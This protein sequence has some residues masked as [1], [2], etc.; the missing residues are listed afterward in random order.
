MSR[1]RQTAKH[2]GQTG[3][4]IIEV[5]IAVAVV[6]SV[7]GITYSIM[8]RNILIMR[9]NQERTEASKIA[10]AQVEMLKSAWNRTHP[11]VF[12][13]QVNGSFCVTRDGDINSSFT[14]A[15][16]TANL[17]DDNL[18]QYPEACRH[19]YYSAAIKK[20]SSQGYTATVRWDG[21]TGV[22]NE[23]VIAYRL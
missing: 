7:L 18:D 19:S 22:R 8:N 12:D 13:A 2:L 1:F 10:Q 3:D 21:V 14:G 9:D 20:N 16:H 4:T 17:Q 6:G 5:L 23:V 11:D 15:T